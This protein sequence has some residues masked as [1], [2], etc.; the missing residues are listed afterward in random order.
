MEQNYKK[1]LRQIDTLIFDVDGVLTRGEVLVTSEGALLR[2]MTVRD[3]YALKRAVKAGYNVCVISGGKN[4]GVRKRL[5]NLGVTDIHLGIENK[6]DTLDEYF[7]IY[8]IKPENTAYMGDD[9]P[10]TH[11]MKL[12][13]LPA[14]PQDAAPEV[15]II[16]TYISHCNGG[17]GCARDLIEQVMK[18]QEKW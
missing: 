18:I 16:S 11:P 9:V 13:G 15:K 2:S 12:V 6:V 4:E 5:R 7:D 1:T 14:C 3:G 8:N 10:D 17:E